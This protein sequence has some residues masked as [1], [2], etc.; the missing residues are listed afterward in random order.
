MMKRLLLMSMMLILGCALVFARGQGSSSSSS[1][2]GKTPLR[3]WGPAS[4]A[5]ENGKKQFQFTIGEFKK[6]Y[7]TIELTI[8]TPLPGSDYRQQ[9]DRALMAGN[10][11]DV[12][13]MFPPVDIPTRAK[14]GTIKD[15]T[16]LVK[17]WDLKNQGK[18]NSSFDE[19]LFIDGKWYAIMDKL[20]VAAT[21]YNRTALIAGGGDPNNLPK[22][23]SEFVTLGVKVTDPSIPRFGYLLMGMEWN[24]WPFTPWVWS[25]GGEMVRKNADGTYKIA[26]NEEPGVDAAEMWNAMVWKYGITQKDV[27]KNWDEL[28]NDFQAGRGVF[29]WDNFIGAALAG[30]EKYGQPLDTFGSMPIPG[31][32][33]SHSPV[34][35]CGGEV[36][37]FNPRIADTSVQA[38]WNWA[39]FNS[40][41][42]EYLESK[43]AFDN[44][45]N[46]IDSYIPATD[47]LGDIKFSRYGT[48]WPA[49]WA[50]DIASIRNIARLEPYCPNWNE[51]KNILAP[52]LQQILL[53]EGI[54]RDE[55]RGILNQA[56]DEAYNTYPQ[57]FKR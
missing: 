12:T 2:G 24:A 13:A 20:Y 17:N 36:W 4:D 53:K 37:T 43:W 42:R 28:Q 46:G 1:S 50:R 38:A 3:I 14:N 34:A 35:L 32:D 15:I 47:E 26:F 41:D 33:A 57:S 8:D 29:A 45:L 54:S 49:H 19:A 40:Y 39:M 52:Y 9:Y 7:P 51:L 55:I 11:P 56:A 30:K 25:A 21:P 22:T 44:T 16:A 18:V 10:A 27:L 23:W 5:T 6:R 31:K 48:G